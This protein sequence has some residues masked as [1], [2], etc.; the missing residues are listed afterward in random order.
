VS[1]TAAGGSRKITRIF[2]RFL[3]NR[4][5]TYWTV[6]GECTGAE[7]VPSEIPPFA[8]PTDLRSPSAS[9]ARITSRPLQ[10]IL[11]A[12]TEAVLT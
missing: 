2:C 3:G 8:D 4:P 1:C 11:W 9:R 7:G 12:D 10:T 6:G 5:T